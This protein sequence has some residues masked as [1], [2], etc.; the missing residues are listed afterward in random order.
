ME[1]ILLIA[2]QAFPSLLIKG[3]LIGLGA[4]CAIHFGTLWWNLP[5]RNFDLALDEDTL[6]KE[7]KPEP[8][9]FLQTLQQFEAAEVSKLLGD[10]E[11]LK[12]DSVQMCLA[13]SNLKLAITLLDTR[14]REL[15]KL[16]VICLLMVAA[17][18][19]S[20]FSQETVSAAQ[21][22]V[23]FACPLASGIFGYLTGRTMRPKTIWDVGEN[24]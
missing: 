23:A 18:M 7:L 15:P 4:F 17:G 13:Q 2:E 9:E 1:S 8:V 21:M 11:F 22:V 12:Q 19:Y 10:Q 16:V 14:Q 20:L 5:T 6:P 3:S 24:F